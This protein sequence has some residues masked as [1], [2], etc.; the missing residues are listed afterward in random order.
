VSL[1]R[2]TSLEPAFK[3][4]T[5]FPLESSLELELELELEEREERDLEEVPAYRCCFYTLYLRIQVLQGLASEISSVINFY[6][7]ISLNVII[8]LLV[9]DSV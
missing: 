1:E 4:K 9:C 5:S 3:K 6:L 8:I 7:S 2:K